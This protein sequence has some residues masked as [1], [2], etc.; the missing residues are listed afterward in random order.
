M[1][2]ENLNDSKFKPF[3][4]SKLQDSFKIVGGIASDTT[5]KSNDGSKGKDSLDESTSDGVHTSNGKGVDYTRENI[6]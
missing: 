1:K 6:A 3:E 4:S 2:L 5:Y